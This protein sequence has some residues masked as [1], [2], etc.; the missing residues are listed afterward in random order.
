VLLLKILQEMK[1]TFTSQ[2]PE[3]SEL[4]ELAVA[5]KQNILLHSKIARIR[6]QAERMENNYQILSHFLTDLKHD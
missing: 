5:Q 4:Q 3:N 2:S 1:K 6:E